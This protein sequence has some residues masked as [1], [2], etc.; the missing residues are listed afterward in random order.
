MNGNVGRSAAE[1]SENVAFARLEDAAHHLF[2]RVGVFVML[3][4]F[5]I[6][7]CRF[8]FQGYLDSVGL[9]F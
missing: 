4:G 6:E 7:R 2:G 1:I 3:E 8:R 5:A 9:G